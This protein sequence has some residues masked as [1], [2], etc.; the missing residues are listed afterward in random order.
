LSSAWAS[1]DEAGRYRELRK[2]YAR[3]RGRTTA[4]E[5]VAMIE[6]TA[7]VPAEHETP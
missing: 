7:H 6:A 5:V 4:E 1:L 3:D 2:W